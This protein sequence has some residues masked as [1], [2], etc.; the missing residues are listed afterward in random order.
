[1]IKPFEGFDNRNVTFFPNVL[2]D[3]VMPL[4]SDEEWKVISA[5]I[6]VTAAPFYKL[7]A[8]TGMTKWELS[9]GIGEALERGIARWYYPPSP[10]NKLALN[11]DFEIVETQEGGEDAQ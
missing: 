5:L 3:K 9:K 10:D 8:I 6:R 4:C 2:I 1:M 11:C 7:Q